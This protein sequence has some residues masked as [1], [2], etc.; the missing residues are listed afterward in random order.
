MF[1]FESPKSDFAKSL[2]DRASE[3]VRRAARLPRPIRQWLAFGMDIG[4]LV[5][6]TW[7]AWSLRMG[8]WELLDFGQRAVIVVSVVCWIPIALYRRTYASLIRFSG[9]RTMAGLGI[10]CGLLAVPM[11]I[12]F[13]F[14]GVAGVPRTMALLQPIIFLAFLA[15]SRMAIRFVLNEALHAGQV[16]KPRRIVCI[17]G[18][19]WAGKQLALT[20]RHEGS[21]RLVAF[22]D[23]DPLL[24]GQMIDG[25][26]VFRAGAIAELIGL[27]AIDE[28]FLALPTIK[29]ARRREIVDALSDHPVQVRTLPSLGQLIDGQLRLADLREINV[30]ELLGR[31]PVPPREELLSATI[32]GCVVMVTGAGGSIGSEIA[33]QIVGRRPSRLILVE[34]SEPGLYSIEQELR[35]VMR[36]EGVR[37]DLI[38]ELANVAERETMMRI[39]TRYRPDTLF[40]AAAYKHVPLVESNPLAGIKNNIVGTWNAA[41]AARAHGVA[42]FIL[43]STDKAVRPTNVMGAT[44]RICELILQ[45]LAAV[46]GPTCFSM[47]RFGNVLGS[48]GSVVPLFKHQ[49]AEGGPVTLTHREVT[50]FFMTIPEAASLVVQASA[51]ADGGEVF[52]LDMGESVRIVELATKMIHLSGLTVRD[53]ASPDGDIEIKEVGLRPGEKLYEELLIGDSPEP[54]DHPRIMQARERMLPWDELHPLLDNLRGHLRDGQVDEALQIVRR[55]VPEFRAPDANVSALSH[56]HS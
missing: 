36:A 21:V 40:H 32:A 39:M 17:Y 56:I 16:D 49:I 31:D 46:D 50:R 38:P 26:P 13:M 51:M 22:V 52:V 14:V 1:D 33:R 53:E 54:T 44:K 19:G 7:V 47:V 43:I 34:M 37:F 30:E 27:Q 28:V 18:A 55:L 8:H 5:L 15:V 45:A 25:V 2:L 41:D 12:V 3:L 20:L 24:S 9:G 4:F 11:L 48:S 23:D 10:S 35:D 29:R 42:R 6:A